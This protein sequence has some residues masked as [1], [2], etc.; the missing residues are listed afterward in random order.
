MLDVLEDRRLLSRTWFVAPGGLDTNTGTLVAPLQTIQAAAKL[1]QPG[2]TV[3]IRAGTYRETVTPA[4][5]GTAAAPITFAAYNNEPVVISGADPVAGWANFA[6]AV[7][8]AG[9][10]WDLGEGNNQVFVDGQMINEARW[11]NT[12]FDLSHPVYA[13]APAIMT[14]D[15]SDGWLF[16]STATITDPTL[17]G[18]ANAWAGATIHIGNG[19]DWNVQTGT[20]L[21]SSAGQLTF[22][23]EHATNYEDPTGGDHY[24]LTGSFQ[25]LDAPGEW[26][27][28]PNSGQLYLWAPAGDSPANH[29]IEAKHRTFAF[30]LSGKSYINV[31]GLS[32][33][34]ASI[35][36]NASSSHVTING[37]TARYVSQA[38]MNPFPWDDH[39]RAATTGIQLNGTSN[40]L[41]N[42]VIAFSSG[43][44]VYVGG[45]NNL[46]QN[47]QVHDV[48]YGGGDESA[49]ELEG[50]N[51][52]VLG[53]TL[54]NTGRDGIVA[55]YSIAAQ[56]LNNTIH[57]CGLQ[58]TDLGAI[59]IW[60]TNGAGTTIAGNTIY[61]MHAGGFGACGIYLDTGCSNYVVH[62]NAITGADTPIKVNG[63][64]SN[65]QLYNN[66]TSGGSSWIIPPSTPA[67]GTGGGVT[68][69]GSLGGARSEAQAVNNAGQ[70]V[71]ASATGTSETAYIDS[72]G[73]MTNAGT[74]GGNY[75]I[76]YAI[77]AAGQF[78][79]GAYGP[80]G[81]R[82]AYLDSAGVMTGL[83]TLPGDVGSF[84]FAL[85]NT[86]SVV[87]ESYNAG[88]V[89]RAFLWSG[90]TMS[91][92]PTLGG[93]V[94]AA[95]GVNDAGLIVGASTLA[96]NRNAHAFAYLN[97]AITGLGTL[98]GSSSYALAVNGAGTIVGESRL[99]DDGA[100][101]AFAYQNGA[102][103]DL[104]SL[105]GL[106]NSVA[107][108]INANGDVVGYAYDASQL[109]TQ[110]PTEHA[111]LYRNGVMYDLN[112]IYAATGWTLAA[113]N[114]IND[115]GQI[116]GAGANPSG[117]G[118][119]FSIQ[120][121]TTP[122][123][124]ATFLKTDTTTGGTW[125]GM[126]GADGYLIPGDATN[127]PSYASLSVSNA[128]QCVW[129]ASAS[130]S[131]D[132]Q[133]APGAS[134]R[135]ASCDYSGASFTLDLNLTD[136][137]A[138]PVSFYCLDWDRLGRSQTIQVSDAATGAVLDTRSVSNFGS[139]QW[140]TW[141]LSGH[142]RI[143]FSNNPGSWN[144]VLGGVFFGPGSAASAPASAAFVKSD[145]T[146]SGH[147]TGV[148]GADGYS[149]VSGQTNLP[150]YASLAT[151]GAAVCTWATS[152]SDSRDLQVGPGSGSLVAACDYSSGSF[153]LDLNLTDG[154]S[155]QVALYLL[156]WDRLNRS[157]TIQV[158]DAATGQLLDSRPAGGFGQGE[159]L[160]WDLS[161]HV[162]ITIANNAGSWNA[163]LGGIFFDSAA[164][165][166]A[167]T[168]TYAGADATTAGTWT[169]TYGGD[170]YS[171]P[172][173]ATSLPSYASL[174]V[175][176]AQQ[177]VWAPSASES[178]DLQTAS[179][180]STRIASCDYSASSFTLDLNLTDG[181]PH[182]VSLYFL[183]WDRLGRSQTVQVADAA[184]GTVLDTRSLSNFGNGQWLTWT[185][186]GHV[187]ITITNN[188]GSWNAVL[189]GVFFGTGSAASSSASATFLK[190]DTTTQ[191]TWSGVY[192]AQGYLAFQ[193]PPTALPAYA[194][195]SLDPAEQ[196]CTWASNQS[197][198]RALRTAPG[199]PSGLAACL[200]SPSSFT[201]DLNLTDGQAHTVA[202]YLL[203]WDRRGRSQTV[204]VSD[205]T[206]GAVLDTR[207]ASN[208]ANGQWLVW[209]LKGH[210][211]L[212]FSNAPGSW[213]AVASGIF[214]G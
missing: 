181:K 19:V 34:A 93:N 169:G 80:A 125:T 146:T 63:P 11:P 150:S 186:S 164:V 131:R 123:G 139:G 25:A 214:F 121:I 4:N 167:S 71:G 53:N 8:K 112:G 168:V 147:W 39:E 178:R 91:A 23:F 201:L 163:V 96:G 110:G 194:S 188:P 190:A 76:G 44:G 1:A 77:N 69:L 118:R 30:E 28:D 81:A 32:I 148:Y 29:F 212:T 92:L 89:G 160:A 209:S 133:T 184:T 82:Q 183:D 21:N 67:S 68:D 203:D 135:I 155:H 152:T 86:G 73:A 72:N 107:T 114:G 43:D 33:F 117:Y 35:D 57:D 191:G 40:V 26:Y 55:T 14:T 17:P 141:T 100:V 165:V 205:A 13:N 210:V 136:G 154:K 185:L 196:N 158:R 208:F 176:N 90:G 56:I 137:K 206:T 156:D 97:G 94:S 60:G 84:A 143:T 149:V 138:H 24:Y 111:F 61:N 171:I 48:D 187:K 127:L 195:L 140:L 99:A 200:Y 15:A 98:G 45:S 129:A 120:P 174:S 132:L 79:G 109:L 37:I 198:P 78:V 122:S 41:E 126:Y 170:G 130:E 20:V 179:G 59:Y 113:A 180:S 124:T 46:V 157:E 3:L 204:Q 2:D 88:G 16:P 166:P 193:G 36:T 62:D 162:T 9:Q 70:I 159:Y 66:T 115:N 153:T 211:K 151:P 177:C 116:V 54:Y 50:S 75:S 65:I 119:P 52:Q 197:D 144:A 105:P 47:N 142:V 22:G 106:P 161:G 102:M 192:G 74:L 202:L 85:N 51:Q 103:K 101:H 64:D 172:G 10:G 12:S 31:Q 87:G 108:A 213:N 145:A 6:G 104:G 58:T 95:F 27:R 134:T 207:A 49:I 5:S 83:G 189:G 7:Y 173:A 175:S 182:P 18:G 128:Q 199:A 38:M 42:S